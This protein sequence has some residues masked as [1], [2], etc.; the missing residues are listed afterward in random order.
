MNL[1]EKYFLQHLRENNT[2][3]SVGMAQAADAPDVTQFSADTYAQDDARMMPH[4][5]NTKSIYDGHS[6]KKKKKKEKKLPMIRR[7][8]PETIFLHGKL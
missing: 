4:F 5:S 2:V 6:T 7:A 8:A 3:A 1:F